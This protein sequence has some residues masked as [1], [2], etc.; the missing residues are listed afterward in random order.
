METM[1]TRSRTRLAALLALLPLSAAVLAGCG[2][3]EPEATDPDPVA[4]DSN[5]A[6]PTETT[7]AAETTEPAPTETAPATVAVPLY[8]VGD[9]PQGP[10]LYREF[11]NGRGR[12]PPRRGGGPGRRR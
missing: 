10:A 12:Q 9:T 7:P 5:P 4:S 1:T 6:P 8:F 3:E 11:R 2:S